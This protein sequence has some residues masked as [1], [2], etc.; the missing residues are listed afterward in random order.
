MMISNSLPSF[1]LPFSWGLICTVGFVGYWIVWIIY[2]RCFHPLAKYPGPFLA[3]ISR[4]WI[5][6]QVIR[7]KAE[8]TQ[9]DLHAKFGKL[10]LTPF[11]ES[12]LTFP[13]PV[14]RIAPNEVAIADPQAI[15]TIYSINSGFTKVASHRFR[16][17]Y[18]VLT[19]PQTDFYP[20][21]RAT[22]GNQLPAC[23]K[24]NR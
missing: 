18:G 2:A 21:F 17:T 23:H 3:S 15:K 9:Q 13:G 5:M 19:G 20:P 12:H 16:S 7:A 11:L 4:S 1:S 10:I 6:M 8:K 24:A 22:F 14:I